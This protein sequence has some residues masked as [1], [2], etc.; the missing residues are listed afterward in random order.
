MRER[1]E[2]Q[3]KEDKKKTKNMDRKTKKYF[4]KKQK[5]RAGKLMPALCNI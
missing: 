3:K 2:K 5:I 4:L 1:G